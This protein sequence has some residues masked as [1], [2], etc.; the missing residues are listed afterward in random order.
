MIGTLTNG[1]A[2]SNGSRSD[3]VGIEPA[4]RRQ[5]SVPLAVVAAI[6][7]VVSIVAFVG[8]QLASSDRR[9]VLAVARP[10]EAGA[11]ITEADLRVAQVTADPALSPIPLSAKSTVVGRTAAV[12][13]RPGSL[14]VESSL[15]ASSVIGDGE[16]LV[17]VEV[18][19][20]SAPVGAVRSGDRV[21]LIEVPK[22]GDAKPAGSATVI[23]EGRVLRVSSAG[24]SASATTQLSLIVP[25]ASGPAVAAASAGQRI[26]L[27]VIP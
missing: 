19:A 24:S 5:R 14:L 15:G 17:G 11:V 12:D 25:A 3:P 13:L 7:M 2:P 18:A 27:V 16:A 1:R 4:K 6:C 9:P 21:R 20:A 8:L 22:A 10:I 23:A 26:A